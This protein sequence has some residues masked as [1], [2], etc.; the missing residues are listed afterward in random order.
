[1]FST[2]HITLIVLTLQFTTCC[3][4]SFFT[5]YVPCGLEFF[6]PFAD[7]LVNVR[8]VSQPVTQTMVWHSSKVNHVPLWEPDIF[9]YCSELGYYDI[10]SLVEGI[11]HPR[12]WDARIWDIRMNGLFSQYSVLNVPDHMI[13]TSFYVCNFA[14]ESY[15][16]TNL[17][18]TPHGKLLQSSS[19]SY[20]LLWDTGYPSHP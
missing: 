4:T 3:I 13:I 14:V 11:P 7:D 6:V 1:M 20:G 5:Y 2:A 15:E 16:L 8:P 18:F 10:L 12:T 17:V 9:H 19:V